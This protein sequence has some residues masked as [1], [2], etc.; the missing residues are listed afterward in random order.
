MNDFFCS[1]ESVLFLFSTTKL[2][3]KTILVSSHMKKIKLTLL[4][5]ILEYG[6]KRTTSNCNLWKRWYWKINNP[7]NLPA[8]LA[9]HG[10]QVMAVGC[11][12]KAYSTRLLLG[13]LVQKTIF[14]TLREKG[15]GV[16][17]DSIMK[18]GYGGIRCVESDGPDLVSIVRC[19]FVKA[20]QRRFISLQAVK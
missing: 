4:K 1:L 6:K 8:G 13:G 17:L 16:Q 14:D 7:Q 9:Q 12:P 18:E 11:D 15:Q 10:K 3:G 5:E 19:L 2:N 20:K